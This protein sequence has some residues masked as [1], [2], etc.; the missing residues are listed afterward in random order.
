MCI[1]IH[2]LRQP[3]DVFLRWQRKEWL[4]LSSAQWE[5]IEYLIELTAP[6]NVM[7]QHAGISHAPSIHDAF[8]I[9]N[10]LF[11]H[12]EFNQDLLAAKSR[13]W[14]VQL[15]DALQDAHEKLSKYYSKASE[16][17][18]NHVYAFAVLLHPG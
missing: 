9:Y 7:T 18:L 17:K 13:A 1:R 5:Q 11:D 15:H 8:P 6:F 16:E 2:I 12:I 3:L 4:I 14:K 10:N